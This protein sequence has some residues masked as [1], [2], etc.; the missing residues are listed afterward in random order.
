MMDCPF[1]RIEP[2]EA[3]SSPEIVRRRVLLPAPFAPMTVVIF[4][5]RTFIDTLLSA[6]T[7]PKDV[8]RSFISSI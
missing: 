5:S 2:D 3:F 6:T 1:H 8:V 4:D 7:D